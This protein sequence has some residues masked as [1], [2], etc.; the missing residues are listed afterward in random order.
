MKKFTKIIALCLSVAAL[1]A[2][3]GCNNG[4]TSNKTA[5][6]ANWNIR[7]SSSVEYDS[8]DFWRNNKEVAS[9]SVL[10]TKGSNANYSVAYTPAAAV[11]D[12][13]KSYMTDGE[14]TTAFYID[15]DAYDWS[16][17]AIPEKF[18]ESDTTSIV[19]VFE[20]T[21]TISGKY[22]LKNGTEGDT[23]NDEIK[24]VCKFRLAGDNLKPVY[25][26]QIIKNTAA[27]NLSASTLNEACVSVNAEHETF[28]NYKCNK[29][30]TFTTEH[31]DGGDKQS[32]K[33][34]SVGGS[35]SVFDNS[36]LKIAA[37]AMALTSSSIKVFNVAVPQSGTTQ[38]LSAAASG[39]VQLSNETEEGAQIIGA[40]DGAD[41][42]IFF[43]DNST[44][45]NKKRNYR[46]NAVTLSL[47]AKM[48]GPTA[49]NWYLTMENGDINYTR[50]V[51]VKSTTPLSFGMGTLAYRLKNLKVET[52]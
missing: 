17:E 48:T 34:Y 15:K 14:Y 47:N 3:A 9:Y 23:F 26:K 29:A 25:S 10:F 49:T 44:D 1:T 52:F 28:Y 2:L 24:T 21:Y 45:E 31:S 37:R 7:T 8:V 35:Y 5:T 11:N 27:R 22:V 51:M 32:E 41:G 30:I 38:S 12:E 46:F 33:N 39:A 16:S 20:T 19:Y 6:S 43:R 18:R 50:C 36:Q 4:N 13:A 40:L 42:Y